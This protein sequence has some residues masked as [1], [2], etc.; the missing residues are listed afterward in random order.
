[1]DGRTAGDALSPA[2]HSPPIHHHHRHHHLAFTA[3]Q[4]DGFT[5]VPRGNDIRIAKARLLGSYKRRFVTPSN[6]SWQHGIFS[7]M[8]T[9]ANWGLSGVNAEASASLVQGHPAHFPT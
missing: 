6:Y 2:P 9:A 5:L 7:T 8:T 4:I 1:M 3:L